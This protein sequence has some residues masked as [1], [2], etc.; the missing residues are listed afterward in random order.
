MAALP[1]SD[2]MTMNTGNKGLDQSRHNPAAGNSQFNATA[3]P[4]ED[5]PPH[6]TPE[7]QNT[8]KIKEMKEWK[9]LCSLIERD[10]TEI[11]IRVA[12]KEFNA[13]LLPIELRKRQPRSH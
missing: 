12:A 2:P 10:S 9:Y 6:E 5:A 1:A 11:A 3:T 8:G 13:L 4:Q 7:V